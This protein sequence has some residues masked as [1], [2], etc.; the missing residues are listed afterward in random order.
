MEYVFSSLKTKL[1][2]ILIR[3][4]HFARDNSG[5]DDGL[6]NLEGILCGLSKHTIATEPYFI[7]A[8]YHC[9]KPDFTS[10]F[11]P[12]NDD[13]VSNNITEWRCTEYCKINDIDILNE[14]QEY[15]CD[16]VNCTCI[17]LHEF[18]R[19]SFQCSSSGRNINKK[20]HPISCFVNPLQCRSQF[21]KLMV[22]A[23]HFPQIRSIRGSLYTM[24]NLSQIVEKI[25]GA[26]NTGNIE[27]I[28][29]LIK[30]Y[31][32]NIKLLPANESDICLNENEIREKFAKTIKLF[33]K[34]S[35]NLPLI[36][37]ISCER[38]CYRT[39]VTNV[40]KPEI[41]NDIWNTL[42]LHYAFTG[43]SYVCHNCLKYF[44]TNKIPPAS[45][46][47]NLRTITA[48]RLLR[49]LNSYEKILLQRAKPFQTILKM[50]T[51]MNRKV[52]H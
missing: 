19:K 11:L 14:L 50:G 17:K 35:D 23:P 33:M 29:S 32:E 43:E 46:L 2:D 6:D 21:L 7:D 30:K 44:K 12:Y 51:V 3:A 31:S 45:V 1:N 16:I 27:L 26:L 42:I 25:D 9:M 37:C 36:P 52:P 10:R 8:S 40:D 22:L 5:N 48:P 28:S 18:L 20:G 15:Y 13:N 34:N 47:N 24:M 38:L 49:D 39:Y 4:Q 41:E